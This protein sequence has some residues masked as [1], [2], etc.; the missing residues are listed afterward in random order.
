LKKD[1]TQGLQE[2]QQQQNRETA[3]IT[4][5]RAATIDL[6]HV[7]K[8]E[9]KEEALEENAEQRDEKTEEREEEDKERSK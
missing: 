7:E 1:V 8:R 3:Q 5:T 4:E 9:E 6:F 2:I